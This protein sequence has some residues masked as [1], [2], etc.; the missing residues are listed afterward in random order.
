MSSHMIGFAVSGH[1]GGIPLND[2]D[3][4]DEGCV[5]EDDER[6]Y[7][8]QED[9]NRVAA[10]HF[11]RLRQRRLEVAA[12][13][14]RE[15][16]L[17]RIFVECSQNRATVLRATPEQCAL[18]QYRPKFRQRVIVQAFAGGGKTTLCRMLAERLQPL[19]VLYVAYNRM[20]AAEAKRDMPSNVDARTIHS[21]ALRYLG[22]SSKDISSV[23][24]Q[25]IGL[26]EH[27]AVQSFEE[28]CRTPGQKQPSHGEAREAWAAM[29][30]GQ[31]PYTY[32][33]MLKK[34]TIDG[35]KSRRWLS[36][37]YDVLIV[38][39][40]QDS[41][42]TFVNWF[43]RIDDMLLYAVGDRFQSI[44]SFNGTVNAM[45][46]LR[47]DP[48]C[49]SS[50][51]SSS[52]SGDES[53]DDSEFCDDDKA[54]A[55][56]DGDVVDDDESDTDSDA[57][58]EDDHESAWA[59]VML[60]AL[61][62]SFR[63]GTNIGRFASDILRRAALYPPEMPVEATIVQ[64]YGGGETHIRPSS[65]LATAFCDGGAPIYVLARQNATLIKH[66]LRYQAQRKDARIAFF[67]NAANIVAQ[68]REMFAQTSEWRANE[69]A[70]LR[71]KATAHQVDSDLV[72]PLEEWEKQRLAALRAADRQP[73]QLVRA[74]LDKIVFQQDDESSSRSSKDDSTAL[75]D[76]ASACSAENVSAASSESDEWRDEQA[77]WFIEAHANVHYGT[78]HS[79][80][81]LEFDRV[82]ILDDMVPLDLACDWLRRSGQSGAQT[83][84]PLPP[85]LRRS[86]G[87][88]QYGVTAR[89]QVREEVHLCYVAITRVK[90]ELFLEPDLL[91]F[92]QRAQQ[93]T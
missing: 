56:A 79:S 28:F 36:M 63:F 44:Y 23:P 92:A 24:T 65:A 26:T 88:P 38:D 10:Q 80:K 89:D 33:A 49:G 43:E 15:A 75:D 66:A 22:G 61:S 25:P 41:Q 13:A 71:Q 8:E 12:L 72:P 70:R 59:P 2:D 93:E 20:A 81:G 7:A 17:Q 18:L 74:L 85:A 46:S 82:A 6:V 57:V 45:Q 90:R 91:H 73:E 47:D 40:A 53:E 68:L 42:P 76:A 35:A 34:L 27:R 55:K 4:P 86:V 32:D 54:K 77:E 16:D 9:A 50:S 37:H 58:F 87:R 67:G 19:K 78:V 62:R 51:S 48:Y 3:V 60:F 21:L 64:G 31:A 11:A 14:I 84:V 5:F 69:F 29:L 39:E 30:N 52:S 1:C 83:F